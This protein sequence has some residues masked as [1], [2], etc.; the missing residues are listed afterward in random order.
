MQ[1]AWTM[2]VITPPRPRRPATAPLPSA[3][4][5]N[6][7]SMN[8]QQDELLEAACHEDNGDLQ[9]LKDVRDEYRAKNKKEE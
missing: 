2:G 1:P 5:E 8:Q 9:H 3:S 4:I 6:A 7:P